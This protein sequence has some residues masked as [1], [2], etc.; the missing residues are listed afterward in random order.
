[1]VKNVKGGSGHKAQGRKFTTNTSQTK[2][3]LSQDNLEYYAQVVALLGNGMCHVMCKDGKKR[4]CIIRGKFRGRGK[5]DNIIGTGSW[6]LVGGREYESVENRSG[7]GKDLEKCDLLEIYSDLDK[8]R[9]KDVGNFSDFIDRD[10]TFSN[11]KTKNTTSSSNEETFVFSNNVNETEYSE[12]MNS[13]LLKT[14]NMVQKIKKTTII[15]MED[16]YEED[17]NIDDI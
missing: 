17:V 14:T 13:T 12:I 8:E 15:D 11:I 4:L 10:N 2:T 7:E 16:E 6:V 9:L 1:M 5:R 3:R